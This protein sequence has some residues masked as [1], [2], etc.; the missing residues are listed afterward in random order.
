MTYYF[1]HTL[2][3]L[4]MVY[5]IPRDDK[6]THHLLYLLP[7]GK[8]YISTLKR[9]IINYLFSNSY[10]EDGHVQRTIVALP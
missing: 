4:V 5:V 1:T 3:C 8:H 2:V 10:T 7:Y 6:N 9:H